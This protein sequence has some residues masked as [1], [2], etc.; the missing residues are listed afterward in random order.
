MIA[1][2][3]KDMWCLKKKRLSLKTAYYRPIKNPR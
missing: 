1:S 2:K 3:M